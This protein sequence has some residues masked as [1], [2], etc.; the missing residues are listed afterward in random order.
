M[1]NEKMLIVN[2]KVHSQIKLQA[3]MNKMTIKEYIAYLANN[4][5]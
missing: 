2:D 3:L 1:K 4:D 5:K